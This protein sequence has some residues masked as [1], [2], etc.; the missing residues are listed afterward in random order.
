[1]APK[2]Q[3]VVVKN[4]RTFRAGDAARLAAQD[5][6]VEATGAREL[7]ALRGPGARPVRDRRAR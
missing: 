1:M 5:D 7:R 6:G 2:V 3:S 4:G